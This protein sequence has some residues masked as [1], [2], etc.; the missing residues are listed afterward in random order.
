MN[1]WHTQSSNC[2]GHFGGQFWGSFDNI[3]DEYIEIANDLIDMLAEKT[4]V[5]QTLNDPSTREYFWNK[6]IFGSSG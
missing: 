2:L 5:H 1:Y 3:D 4:L 6:A